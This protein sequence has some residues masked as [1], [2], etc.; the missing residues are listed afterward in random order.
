MHAALQLLWEIYLDPTLTAALELQ[1]A[2]RTDRALLAALL[3]VGERHHENILRLAREYF[4]EAAAGN[5]RF[6]AMLD[7]LLDTFGGLRARAL[8]RPDDPAIPRTLALLEDL[9]RA[10]LDAPTGDDPHA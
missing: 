5:P 8:L 2:A 9:A 6:T 1:M 10:A 3:P 7:L 4:P